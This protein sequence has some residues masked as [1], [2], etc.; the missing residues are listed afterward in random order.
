M[1]GDVTGARDLRRQAFN[2]GSSVFPGV[3]PAGR[4][5]RSPAVSP[6][7]ATSAIVSAAVLQRPQ[8]NIGGIHLSKDWAQE[9]HVRRRL[10]SISVATI[11]APPI[12]LSPTTR[13]L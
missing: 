6:S 9:E 2:A 3:N 4:S 1:A 13:V 5:A 8:E 7:P 10:T 12:D 11:V